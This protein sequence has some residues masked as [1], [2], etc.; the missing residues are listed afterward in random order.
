MNR[1]EETRNIRLEKLKKLKELGIDAYP[2][3]SKR[4]KSIAQIKNDFSSIVKKNE[5]VFIV[6]R[7][8]SIR[9]HG[10]SCF[11][12]IRD[13]D[14]TF[15]LFIKK[16]TIGEKQFKGFVEL[17]DISDI[18]EA[19]GELFTSKRGEQSLMVKKVRLLSKALRAV[20]D[21]HYGLKDIE[22]RLRKRYLDM[23]TNKETRELFVK[24]ALF[25]QTIRQ[26]MVKNDYLE[27]ETPVLEN[28]PGGAEAE[29]FITHHNKLDRD[30]YLRISLE[31]PLKRLLVGG[32][33]KVF[34]IG[35]IFRN[36]G[37]SHEHLQDYTQLEFYWA[38]ADYNDLKK[39][40]VKLFQDV[41]KKINGSTQVTNQNKTIDFGNKWETYDYY[42]LFKKYTKIDLSN[43]SL[44]ELKKK[45]DE[46]KIKHDSHIRKGR[47]IDLIYKKC[48]RPNL[49]E[50]GFLVDPPVEI[51]PLAKRCAKDPN[52]VQRLQVL[53][54]GTELGKGFTE[55]NDPL[56][57][58][59]RFEEQMKLREAGD[60]EAQLI[61]EDY[62]EAMEYGMPPNTGF[63]LSERLFSV[64]VDKPIRETVIFPP[65]KEEGQLII[66]N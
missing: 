11:V 37:L 38:Y 46:L 12:D 19:E 6:G 59:K 17:F 42:K 48:V 60:K 1:Q 2:S 33:N 47:L 25:W 26:F 23:V 34:E 16:D 29:P 3:E 62:I 15:Q 24:K 43:T 10:G 61:D 41:I 14:D 66:K 35:R 58:R 21:D 4:S 28:V 27:V 36:E 22:T 57:Q 65:M 5:P 30:F 63:G 44:E 9:K 20:P 40:I 53:A 45:A 50:P 8:N 55:L 52:R 54:W 49:I 51:E 18:I 7:I 64:L 32:Y 56:D 13:S 31:L 39:F